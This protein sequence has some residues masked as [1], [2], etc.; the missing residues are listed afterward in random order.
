[1][2]EYLLTTTDNP[3]NPFDNFDRWYNQD[4]LLARQQGRP[5]V[6]SYLDR[7]ARVNSQLPDGMYEKAVDSAIDEIVEFNV[8]GKYRKISE[9][10]AKRTLI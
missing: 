3:Y 1:M 2:S 8:T 6:C 5:D 10:E 4:L 9:E 7:I